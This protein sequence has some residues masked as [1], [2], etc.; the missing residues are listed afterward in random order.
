VI[1]GRG[2]A[3]RAKPRSRV[4][5]IVLVALLVLAGAFAGLYYGH[6]IKI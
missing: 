2:V 6:V 5:L 4:M 3:E 1:V